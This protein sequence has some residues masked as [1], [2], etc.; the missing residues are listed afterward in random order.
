MISAAAGVLVYLLLAGCSATEKQLPFE[1]VEYVKD[2]PVTY[3]VRNGSIVETGR[4]GLQDIMLCG[5]DTLL[6]STQDS[7]GYITSLR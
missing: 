2:F 3:D 6:I 1:D 5:D 4:I 7:D